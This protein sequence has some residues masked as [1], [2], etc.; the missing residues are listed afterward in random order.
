MLWRGVPGSWGVC[1]IHRARW[2]RPSPAA[3]HHLRQPQRKA[4]GVCRPEVEMNFFKL[5]IG[6]YQRDTAHLSVT[7]HGA[8][9]LMLQHYYATE[10]P[11]PTG[12]ALHRMLRAQDKDERDAIDSVAAQFWSKTPEGLLVNERA[13]DEITKAGGQAET[14]TRIAREREA[15]RIAARQEH[16]SCTNRATN[17][18]PNQTPDTRHQNKKTRTPPATRVPPCPDGVEQQVWA[19]WLALRR[20][21]KAPVTQT[22]IDG[23][24]AEATKAGMSLD[25]FLRVW[26]QRG[27]QGLQADWLK[28][29]ERPSARPRADVEPEWRREQR[30]RNEAFFGPYAAT[31]RPEIIDAEVRDAAPDLLD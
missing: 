3:N 18:Q 30:E 6:D 1:A 16:E 26:C 21:K 19:D 13:A 31:R 8:Y 17:D 25:D 4:A 15:R 11:L 24:A 5:Y 22:A 14:N 27:S 2:G 29:H 23:A 20:A 12:K 28:P 7:E 9:M 10:K